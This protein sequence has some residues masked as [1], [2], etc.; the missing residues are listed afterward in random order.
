M[1]YDK[2]TWGSADKDFIEAWEGQARMTIPVEPGNRHYD[3]II[4][5]GWTIADYVE[6]KIEVNEDS[7]REEAT[8]R[9]MVQFYCDT[10]ETLHRVILDA[11]REA[12]RLQSMRMGVP[13]IIDAKEWTP[14]QAQRAATL[15]AYDAW[16]QSVDDA[17]SVLNG[18][19]PEDYTDDKHWPKYIGA[20]N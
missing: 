15:I 17:A 20:P 10:E 14:E 8:R 6:P 2:L 16:L 19:L 13:G 7:I 18:T 5:E 3:E 11:D 1:R 12:T 9:K 4:R